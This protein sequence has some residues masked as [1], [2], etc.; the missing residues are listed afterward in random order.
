M[1]DG[2]R[3]KDA[4]VKYQVTVVEEGK[5]DEQYVGVT[6]PP[7]KGRYNNH[8]STFRHREKRINSALAGHICKLKYE[9]REYTLKWRILQKHTTY[10]QP[11]MC[12]GCV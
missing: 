11:Q 5:P 7:F 2:A 10:I 4:K 6:E 9:G 8:T 1:M 12:V 3:C